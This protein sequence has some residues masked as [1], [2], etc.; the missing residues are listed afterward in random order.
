MSESAI[1]NYL[2]SQGLTD[3]GVAG[4]MGNLYAESGLNPRNLQ[5]SYEKSLG[6]DDDSYTLAVDNGTYT[7]FVNDSAG[8]GLAQWTYW[9]RK[10]ALLAYCK[11][12]GASIGSLDTQLG[13]LM[14]E[15]SEGY[16]SV[17]RVLKSTSSIL[18]A[19][20]AVLL[21]FER[22][23][24]QSTAVQNKRASYG[25]SFY[26]KYANT[27]QKGDA[28][29]TAVE[30]LLQT[31][32]NEIGYLEKVTNSQLDSKTGNA[33]YNN[34]TKYARDLDKIGN[35]YNGG[36]NGY[37]WCDVFVDWCF[38]TTFGVDLGMKLLCQAY[39]GAGAGCT[40]SAQYY[41][42]KGQFYTSNPQPGDQIF[43]KDGDGMGHTGIVEKVA[44]GY[45]YTIE[46]NTSSDAG[47]V[48]NGGSVNSKRYSLSYN[49][50]GGY[51]RPNWSLVPNTT[52]E[53]DD[54]MDV[55]RFKE[56]WRE[57]RSEL[58]DNDAGTW[59]EEAREWAKSTGLVAG[60][61]DKEFNGAWEDL[62]T[63]EQLVTVLYRF[64]KMIGQA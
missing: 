23:A 8:Y 51:G 16:Q 14:K 55:T 52:T 11:A 62:L 7:N 61:S 35:I 29:M 64:A 26:N 25:Q 48:A 15:L 30:R 37:A 54:D 40:Y 53:E 19:S 58:Q 36:K 50:I 1:W 9:S 20:N 43:F 32:R 59:S 3:C 10:Q 4:L 56:L 18:E 41:R 12:S 33:G 57:M 28:T 17:L 2:K 45:V 24:D 47:V 31:A 13:F 34:W 46:G 38:I 39:G 60:T 5:N 21:Q 49:K 44:N 27:T 6:Y 22:P 42:D 63:R